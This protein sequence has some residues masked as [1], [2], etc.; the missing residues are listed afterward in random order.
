[1]F[2]WY[3]VNLS[4]EG[5]LLERAKIG[6]D[7]EQIGSVWGRFYPCVQ[8]SIGKMSEDGAPQKIIDAAKAYWGLCE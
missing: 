2:K 1:M 8:E 4:D 6:E 5:V 3:I 7:G